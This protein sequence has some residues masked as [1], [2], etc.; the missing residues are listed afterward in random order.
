M[1]QNAKVHWIEHDEPWV[2]EES[3]I[4]S[5]ALPLNIQGNSHTFKPLLSALRSK[6]MAEAKLM[7]IADESGLSRRLIKT[8]SPL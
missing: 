8:V 7:E 1:E 4:G 5:I 2:V 6:A 3:L